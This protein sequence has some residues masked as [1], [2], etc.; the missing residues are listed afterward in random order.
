MLLIIY[1]NHD[2]VHTTT[3]HKI[4]LFQISLRLCLVE[5]SYWFWFLQIKYWLLQVSFDG[6]YYDSGNLSKIFLIIIQILHYFVVNRVL[7]NYF[8]VLFLS[9]WN[10]EVISSTP[11]KEKKNMLV[12]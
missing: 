8:L 7:C 12:M 6:F 3:Y 11:A 1:V 9:L 10:F 2:H 5:E 4:N